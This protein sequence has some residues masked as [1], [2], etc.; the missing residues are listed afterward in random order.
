MR[1][2]RSHCLGKSAAIALV[3][4]LVYIGMAMVVIG[5]AFTAFY[6]YWDHSRN[7]R[8]NE[9]DIV[10]ALRAGERW[11]ADVR[12]AA[13]KPILET[14]EQEQ[15]LRIPQTNGEVIYVFSLGKIWRIMAP[16]GRE[17]LPLL[18]LKTS[19][20]TEEPRTHA[21]AWRWEIELP[22]SR[23]LPRVRPLFSFQAV[24]PVAAK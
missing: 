10:Q 19:R 17:P 1:I 9:N 13:A 16:G 24:P 12:A 23:K 20:M 21:T 7:L 6:R 8:N 22:S 4:C 5:L 11:R 18:E 2:K 3:E 15:A 14:A